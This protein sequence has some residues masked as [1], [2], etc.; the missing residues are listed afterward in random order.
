MNIFRLTADMAHLVSFFILILKIW[1]TKSCAGISFK[2]Q[3]LYLVVFLAR[4]LDLFFKFI[5]IYNTLMKIFFIGATV[6]I[7]VVMKTKYRATWDATSD[8]FRVEFL[9]VPS[10]LL[11]LVWNYDFTVVEV[12]WAFSLFLESVAILPQLF[13]L[14]R[15]GQ[16][17]TI[18]AHYLFALGA[19]RG[20]YILNWI[21]RYFF[22]APAYHIAWISVLT[23]LVQTGL[24]VDFFYVYFTKVIKGQKFQLP[25]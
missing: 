17:E 7:C 15:T 3:L 21:Y 19:Y 14:T 6:W 13:M 22:D 23:G 10:F 16:A 24:Y 4:Y 18:T 5:S 20:L 2:S 8:T 9:L 12:L 11:S 1:H 25:A